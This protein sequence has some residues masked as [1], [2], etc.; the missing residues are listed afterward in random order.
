MVM[1]HLTD[2]DLMSYREQES[3]VAD[4]AA[5]RAHLAACADCR[6]NLAT[7]DRLFA[8]MD[9]PVPE[10]GPAYE[11]EMWVRIQDRLAEE[12]RGFGHL[13]LGR[14]LLPQLGLAAGV[15]LLLMG[16]FW[17]ERPGGG[18]T[19]PSRQMASAQAGGTSVGPSKA[20]PASLP[21]EQAEGAAGIRSRVLVAAVG[22][23]LQRAELMLTELNNTDGHARGTI[24][25]TDQQT[26]AEDL[27]NEN[28]LYR[29]SAADVNE[30]QIVAVL[31]DLERVLLEVAHAPAETTPERL[32]RLRMR[33][34]TQD[35]LF[36]VRVV[37]AGMRDRQQV[38]AVVDSP[39]ARPFQ[40]RSR[41]GPTS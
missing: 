22:D 8:M 17:F 30:D 1:A 39:G 32:D 26:W 23:H 41:R 4:T 5:I 14:S 12:P 29:R 11:R 13:N 33:L 9:V 21:G 37:G 27:V 3:P 38:A 28:R 40:A 6:A 15:A 7:L 36:K 34:G 16:L 24:D 2:E 35:V 18:A 20:V 25:L 31:D 10:P 19:A